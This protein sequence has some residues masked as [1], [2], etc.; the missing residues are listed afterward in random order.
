MIFQVNV[1]NWCSR[2]N[3]LKQENFQGLFFSH[4]VCAETAYAKMQYK[5]L[6]S[7]VE[8]NLDLWFLLTNGRDGEPLVFTGQHLRILKIY[9]FLRS[10]PFLGLL[11][12]FSVIYTSLNT[13]LKLCDFS[14][15]KPPAQNSTKSEVVFEHDNLIEYSLLLLS[16]TFIEADQPWNCSPFV[17]WCGG[18]K[19]LWLVRV[20][21]CYVPVS[22]SESMKQSWRMEKGQPLQA[23]HSLRMGQMNRMK[24]SEWTLH[25]NWWTF[26][27]IL[28]CPF[29]HMDLFWV[30][31]QY[32]CLELCTGVTF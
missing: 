17:S 20:R 23:C 6:T 22:C 11:E 18:P 19:I 16:S 9:S 28:W 15:N 21:V 12:L 26:T 3:L 13:Y 8:G 7:C 10:L 2:S 5:A 32:G 1:R 27:T 30:P 4:F 25:L 31:S 14:S 29:K 24:V